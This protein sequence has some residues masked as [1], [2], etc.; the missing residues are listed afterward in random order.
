MIV[1]SPWTEAEEQMLDVMFAEFGPRWHVI[2]QF[3]PHRSKNQVKNQ[4][5]TKQRRLNKKTRK[6]QEVM[7][8]EREQ[9]AV[10]DMRHQQQDLAEGPF[11]QEGTDA[12]FWDF[13]LF[14]FL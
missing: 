3:F 11:Q 9:E 4:W 8:R 13:A 7:A 6:E 10:K 5:M 14:D 1:T 2:A 12:S